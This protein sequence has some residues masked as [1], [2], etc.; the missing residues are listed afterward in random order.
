[1][2]AIRAD[3]AFDGERFVGGGGVTV[4]VEGSTIVAVEPGAG[5]VPADCPVTDH[6]R[7]TVLPGLVDAHVH[8]VADS[9]PMALDR[10]AGYSDDELDAVVTEALRAQRAGGVTTVR[11]LGDRRFNVVDRRDARRPEDDGLPR[12]V[13]SG[14]PITSPRGHC[15]YLGGE[16]ADRDGIAAAVR[17][18][19]ERGVD[20]V[21]VMASGGMNTPGTDVTAPQFAL[22]DL[23]LLVDLAHDAGLPVTAHSHAAAGIDQAVAV[24]VDGIE[25]ASYLAGSAL[26]G[27]AGLIN[28]SATDE[29]L[30]A[31]AA[32]GITVCPTLGGLSPDFYRKAP[33]HV[34]E[35]IAAAGVTPEQIVD[36]RMALIRRQHEAG[37]RLVT[38]TDGG[39]APPKAHG[40][41]SR[42]VVELSAVVP[43]TEA[44]ATAT[45]RAADV[46]GVGASTGRL[47]AGLDADLLVVEGDL[48]ADLTALGRV[49]QVV[50]AGSHSSIA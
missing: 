20:V 39:I 3:S 21:K 37:V 26:P 22:E 13:A 9:G 36:I 42:A 34:L 32:S 8:L 48:A 29:Q 43:A 49:R 12:I 38:G 46:C 30:A 31:L 17:E 4:L 10:V 50:V 23:R 33:P 5:D 16:V 47:R 14:P 35:L 25:H 27:L 7:A 41:C 2:F 19:V 6:G 40:T 24:G 28:V 18:R 11:D 1:M 44:L 15:H 45:S